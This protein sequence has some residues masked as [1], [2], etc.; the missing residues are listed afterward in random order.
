M[1][2][3]Q[4]FTPAAVAA[5][6]GFDE[7]QAELL[8]EEL[9]DEHLVQQRTEGRYALHDLLRAHAAGYAARDRAEERAATVRV[10]SWYQATADGAA[11]RLFPSRYAWP[12]A[13]DPSAAV[14]AEFADGAEAMA[15]YEREHQNLLAAVERAATAVPD[16]DLAWRLAT[17]LFSYLFVRCQWQAGRR[18]HELG[19]ATAL[20]AGDG[21]AE[22]WVRNNLGIFLTALGRPGEAAPQLTRALEVRRELGDV[23]GEAA[24]LSNLTRVFFESGQ[25]DTA[26]A[27]ALQALATAQRAADRKRE[28]SA[29]NTVAICLHEPG[30]PQESLAYLRRKLAMHRADGDLFGLGLA[31]HNIAELHEDQ[32]Q[33]EQVRAVLREALGVARAAGDRHAGAGAL[34]GIARSL[35]AAGEPDAARPHLS[36][37]LPLFEEL[38]APELAEARALLGRLGGVYGNVRE[39]G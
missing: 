33:H 8:L 15:W 11:G 3:G 6:S 10:L 19:L 34:F 2:P 14:P 12:S 5:S 29:L 25:L 4:D 17:T 1:V 26:L 30:R 31:L 20:G 36:A 23:S 7:A 13:Q 24:T 37:A 18:V 27:Y 32:G 35:H 39:T 38:G 28:S 22:A 21:A 16:T 9:Q